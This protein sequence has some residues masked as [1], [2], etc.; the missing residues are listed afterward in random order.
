MDALRDVDE[1]V[2]VAAGQIRRSFSLSSRLD[3]IP[4]RARRRGLAFGAEENAPIHATV[5]RRPSPK[6]RVC[7]PPIASPARARAIAVAARRGTSSRLAGIR[8]AS[9]SSH[10]HVNWRRPASGPDLRRESWLPVAL[11]S[12]RRARGPW[13]HWGCTTH[14]WHR[15]LVGDRRLS[16]RASGAAEADPFRLVAADAVQQVESLVTSGRSL[17]PGRR[18][19]TVIARAPISCR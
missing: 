1:P 6:L 18:R 4:A 10:E 12:P 9:W 15:D 2:L 17:A 3:R 16:K 8:S 14:H 7:P 13:R 19:S 11:P 5:S